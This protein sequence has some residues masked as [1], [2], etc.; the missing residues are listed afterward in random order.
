[1]HFE[2]TGSPRAE[3]ILENWTAMLPKFIKIFPH[4]YKRVL[5]IARKKQEVET[6][7]SARRLRSRRLPSTSR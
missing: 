2:A 6:V 4:E 5:G 7:S 1:M 3:W